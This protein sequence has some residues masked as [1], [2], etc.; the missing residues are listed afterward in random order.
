ML[1]GCCVDIDLGTRWS[2]EKKG[3]CP[4]AD[5]TCRQTPSG[6]ATL[7]TI[8]TNPLKNRTRYFHSSAGATPLPTYHNKARLSFTEGSGCRPAPGHERGAKN[9]FGSRDFPMKFLQPRGSWPKMAPKTRAGPTPHKRLLQFRC[10]CS[11]VHVRTVRMCHGNQDC[12]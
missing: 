11:I 3:V 10:F 7:P 9:V 6:S 1:C 12:V 4:P 2:C 5:A 8:N